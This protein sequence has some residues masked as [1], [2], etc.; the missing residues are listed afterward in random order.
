MNIYL[1]FFKSL[2]VNLIVCILF[3]S[4]MSKRLFPFFIDNEVTIKMDHFKEQVA[5]F[6]WLC[7]KN[8]FKKRQKVMKKHSM[9]FFKLQLWNIWGIAFE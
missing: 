5:S 3:N 2:L 8:K 7:F 4:F 9:I 6:K 1:V